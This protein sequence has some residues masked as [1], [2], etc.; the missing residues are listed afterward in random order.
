[1]MSDPGLLTGF[2]LTVTAIIVSPGP[3]TMIIIRNSL[4]SGRNVG[5]ATMAGTQGG[6]LG[7]TLMAALGVSV[8]IASSPVLFRTV[9]FAGS[10][11]LA[12]LGAQCFLVRGD[13]KMGKSGAVSAAKGFRD[14][15]ITNLL[16]P[17]VIMMFL[18]L[19]PNFLDL[20][21]GNIPMQL[22]VMSAILLAINIVWQTMLVV[23]ADRAR[24]WLTRPSVQR[25]VNY[26][27]G[28]VLLTFSGLMIWE[29][30]V[31]LI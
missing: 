13:L 14:A 15:M 1:M 30:I 26:A 16:N 18:A 12:F 5:M 24:L 31:P 3:D 11:Y 9:A 29:H 27:T 23:A 4:V 21:A 10:A 19:F 8:V 2:L 6:I 17:K 7:H 28:V 22:L 25:G 20:E